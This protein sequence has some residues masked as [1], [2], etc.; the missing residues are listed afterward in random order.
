MRSACTEAGTESGAI[1]RRESEVGAATTANQQQIQALEAR[2]AVLEKRYLTK[3]AAMELTVTR[4]KST[5][6]YIQNLV[7]M[8]TR[9]S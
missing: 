9:K 4:M 8:W 1:V 6:T 2:A 3:F 7:D 5:G